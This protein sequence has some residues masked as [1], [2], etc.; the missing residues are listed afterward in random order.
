MINNHST[1]T[2]LMTVAAALDT[3]T[4]ATYYATQGLLR[5]EASRANT[6]QLKSGTQANTPVV[7][8]RSMPTP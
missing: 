2:I 4:E 5:N 3:L 8:G 6:P 7:V 1:T